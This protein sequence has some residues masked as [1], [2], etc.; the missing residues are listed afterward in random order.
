MLPRGK[1]YLTSLTACYPAARPL[2]PHFVRLS[3]PSLP[4][5]SLS[6]LCFDLTPVFPVVEILRA[7]APLA[8]CLVWRD[9]RQAEPP[10]AHQFHRQAPLRNRPCAANPPPISLCSRMAKNPAVA[11][12][13]SV[14]W[15]HQSMCWRLSAKVP[16]GQP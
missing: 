2:Q 14:T 15:C 13:I 1:T 7:L 5:T 6:S 4:Y 3:S 16:A 10:S 12:T 8:H 9:W 11:A